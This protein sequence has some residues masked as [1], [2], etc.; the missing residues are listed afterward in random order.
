MS[1][2]SSWLAITRKDVAFGAE[3]SS[4]WQG[5]AKKGVGVAVGQIDSRGEVGGHCHARPAF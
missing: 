1:E 2:K 4:R 3:V 5:M